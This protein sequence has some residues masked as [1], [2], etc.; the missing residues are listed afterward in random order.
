MQ[1]A[2]AARRPCQMMLHVLVVLRGLAWPRHALAPRDGAQKASA[3]HSK[4]TKR[5]DLE[6][7]LPATPQS[8]YAALAPRISA[9]MSQLT[10]P[11]FRTMLS[12]PVSL[13][14]DATSFFDVTHPSS[15]SGGATI[16]SS[17]VNMANT[18]LGTGLL[19]IP[20]CISFAGLI[21]GVV[22]II[23]SAMVTIVTN[24]FI[25][26][27]AEV[28]GGTASFRRLSDAA[29]DRLSI[30][31][32]SAIV[33]TAI[34]IGISY[35]II[36]SNGFFYALPAVFGITAPPRWCF[37]VAVAIITT[38]LSLLRSLDSLRVTSLFAVL[39]LMAITGLVLA[40]ALP[41]PDTGPFVACPSDGTASANS[42]PP[43]RVFAYT[44]FDGA[45]NAMPTLA[46]AFSCQISTPTLWNEIERP[47]RSRMLAVYAIALG[48]A[49][50]MY[51]LVGGFG[52]ATFGDRVLPNVLSSYPL[53]RAISLARIGLSFVVIFSFPIQALAL[54]NATVS[55]L[56]SVCARDSASALATQRTATSA[57]RPGRWDV[58]ESGVALTRVISSRR[59][60]QE[61]PRNALSAPAATAAG[62]LA[63]EAALFETAAPQAIPTLAFILM[64]AGVT[65]TT[66]DLGIIVDISGS[67]GAS[68]ITFVAP[69]II[70]W[71]IFPFHTMG[72]IVAASIFIFGILVI[73]WGLTQIAMDKSESD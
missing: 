15:V 10:L 13:V 60:W 42:C 50:C 63:K 51:I 7:D 37:V 72:R 4:G 9:M 27:A 69:S 2:P 58:G 38:P 59:S 43:G 68:I 62:F 41:S 53:T 5:D 14:R 44:G 54:R 21:P 26:D 46:M 32:N 30:L 56:D 12:S 19:A 31:I 11:S 18:I 16:F 49:M 28:V 34:G 1:T 61:S 71:C 24:V 67:L 35:F 39:I 33:V 3:P 65:L 6:V 25:S 66:S 55:I 22:L 45:M 52:Y 23:F 29:M 8:S 17:A 20:R 57:A 48:V 73:V 36:A 70:Y 40:Y 47:T 64:A